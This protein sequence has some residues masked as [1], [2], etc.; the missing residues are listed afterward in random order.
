MNLFKHK[1][2]IMYKFVSV[3]HFLFIC[4]AINASNIKV[5]HLSINEGLNSSIVSAIKQDKMGFMWFGTHNGMEKFN[6]SKISHYTLPIVNHR[7]SQD[8][9]ISCIEISDEY[10]ILCG[11]KSGKIY[12]FDR[13]KDKFF[14]LLADIPHDDFLNVSSL[15]SEK[16]KGLWIGSPQGLY[17]YNGNLKKITKIEG[18]KEGINKIVKNDQENIWLGSRKGLLLYNIKQDTLKNLSFSTDQANNLKSNNITSIFPISEKRLAVGNSEG[19][20]YILE[21][22][23]EHVR[24]V[25]YK[26]FMFN[27]KSYQVNDIQLSPLSKYAI[28]FDGAG[29]V[30]TDDSFNITDHLY[31]DSDYEHSLS[32]NGVREL[33]TSKDGIFWM[34]TYGGGVNYYDPNIKPFNVIQ[35]IPFVNNSLRVNTI[36]SIIEDDSENVWY[37][38]IKG[39]SIF[40]A[41]SSDWTHIPS[42]ANTEI[43]PMHVMHMTTDRFNNV[44]VATYGN[45]LIKINQ[46]NYTKEYF[47]KS[48]KNYNQ[49]ATNHLYHVI[50]DH[51][52]RIW[53][54][55]IWGNMSVIDP[56]NKKTHHVNVSGIRSIYDDKQQVLV[57]T[58]FGLFIVN[59]ETLTVERSSNN[60]LN[61]AR[62]IT[63]NRHPVK[64]LVYIGTELQGIIVWNRNDD[65]IYT[66]TRED[67][68]PSNNIKSIVW[69]K[70]NTMWISSTGG[71]T[72]FNETGNKIQN[73]GP[74]DGLANKEFKENSVYLL[75]SGLMQLGSINGV[76]SFYP[77]DIKISKQKTIPILTGIKLFGKELKVDE[78][79]PLKQSIELQSDISLNHN[80]N[81][82]SLSF[83]A[84]GFT[85][86]EKIKY[87]WKLDG[88]ESQW[89]ISSEVTEAIYSKLPPGNYTFQLQVTNDDNIWQDQVRTLNIYVEKPFWEKPLAFFIYMLIVAS[90]IFLILHYY[91]TIIHEKHFAEKQQFFITIA[92]DLRTPLS[93]IKLPVEKIL[94]SGK[95]KVN[96]EGSLKIVKRNIDRLT[97][98]VNQLL[99]FQK[100][101]LKKMDLQIKQ[102]AFNQ[103][104]KERIDFFKPLAKEKE[105]NIQFMSC[106]DEIQLWFD[107][108]K[109]E[110]ILYNLLSNAIKYNKNKGTIKIETKVDKKRCYFS[111]SDT[112][113]GIPKKQQKNIFQR[114]FRASNAINST[115]VGSG[116]GLVLTKHLV[117]LHHGEI[118]FKSIVDEGTTF[119]FYLPLSEKVYK[120][121]DFFSFDIEDSKKIIEVEETEHSETNLSKKAPKILLVEDNQELLESLQHELSGQYIVSTADNGEAGLQLAKKIVPD[122]IISDVMMPK[123]SGHQLCLNVKNDI[124]ICHIPVILLTALNSDDFKNEGLEYGADAYIEKPFDLKIL[125]SQ[126]ANLLRNRSMLKNK[127]LIPT[128]SIEDSAPTKKDSIFL[129]KIRSYILKNLLNESLS[130]ET[131]AQQ[132]NMS[133]PVLYRKIK[134]LTNMS[135]QQFVLLV[136]LK[137]AARILKTEKRSIGEITIMIG[138][139]DQKY[140]SNAFKK[141]FGITPS[142]F[143]KEE[144]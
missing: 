67:G 124:S 119:S 137:E 134:A 107:K 21:I 52:D 91:H 105:I 74:A 11:V 9:F 65:S 64:D 10:D 6:G 48:Q 47:N 131:L 133:R 139:T 27:N 109:M 18:I 71:L 135:P 77:N 20:V 33:H 46:N 143:A 138:F 102:Y 93:L 40:N 103:F 45:G 53:T 51:K 13:T 37:G 122:L 118:H 100:A 80:Q 49:T 50:A 35:H 141:Q 42:I 125:L 59:S 81:S 121:E 128:N 84:I 76:T 108:D 4:F 61:S 14:P 62:I 75:K 43:T 60:I 30:L 8:N 39:I 140:F 78:D 110:K 88:F 1:N 136:R 24:I 58:L 142:Q 17:H 83:G 144:K 57:G 19:E 12:Y 73:Y 56:K 127:F 86:P 116:L 26:K 92:H 120:P 70:Q 85:A 44:W 16:N 5:Q 97:N 3:I 112:G 98:L 66:I 101:D 23:N 55:G 123:M 25:E 36:N 72:S 41:S 32:S 22:Q 115:E 99:D 117:E 132:F 95:L 87:K 89:N 15:Y 82:L 34:A 68:L 38:T 29:V 7:I 69:D 113:E 129:E 31:V 111:I 28:S 130:V 104:I 126:I 114:Y 63:I 90:L 106:Q 79:G 54:G 94:S 2:S 96:E